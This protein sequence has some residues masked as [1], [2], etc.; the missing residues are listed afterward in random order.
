MCMLKCNLLCFKMP[1]VGHPCDNIKKHWRC[2]PWQYRSDSSRFSILAPLSSHPYQRILFNTRGLVKFP[3]ITIWKCLCINALP[4]STEHNPTIHCPSINFLKFTISPMCTSVPP[5]AIIN[6]HQTSKYFRDACVLSSFLHLQAR[7]CT[8]PGGI[9]TKIQ[10]KDA[11][12]RENHNSH[13]KT[14]NTQTVYTRLPIYNCRPPPAADVHRH[15]PN[16]SM[17]IPNQATQAPIAATAQLCNP[18]FRMAIPSSVLRS[19]HQLPL[20]QVN[21]LVGSNITPV[22]ICTMCFEVSMHTWKVPGCG[23]S[24]KFYIYAYCEVLL[25]PI[26]QGLHEGVPYILIASFPSACTLTF[27]IMIRPWIEYIYHNHNSYG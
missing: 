20:P 13:K 22:S 3:F 18:Y 9:A 4:L 10:Q 17:A 26:L 7:K 19:P 16:L 12:S 21:I 2:P 11:P 1:H 15:N 25:F 14:F 8:H 27:N 6:H 23:V 5:T 24:S